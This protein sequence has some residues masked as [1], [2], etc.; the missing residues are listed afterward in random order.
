[1]KK[2]LII[3][4]FIVSF[5]SK[6]VAQD[7]HFGVQMSPSFS[8]MRTDNSKIN[9]AGAA[10][11]LKLA[12]IAE[13]RF[14]QSYAI[15]TGIGFHFNTG[16]RLQVDAPSNYW[17]KAWPNFDTKPSGK[18]DSAAFP[19]E[20]R[21]RHSISYV[22]IPVG[23]KMRTPETGSHVRYFAE[24][25]ITFGF[26]S[27]A[28]GA[29]VGSNKLDQEKIDIKSEVS[30]IN[31]SWGVGGGVEYVI[32]NNTAIVGG[33]YFQRGFKDVTTD[34]GTTFDADG[35]SNARADKSKGVINSL[36]IRLGVMF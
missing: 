2:S 27:K 33:L 5:L 28:Q 9:G 12:L 8:W 21:F 16:G 36:T 26:L 10:T 11:G 17:T 14:S 31:M 23:L 30:N 32:S 13:N 29:I 19:K 25:Q 6:T 4:A 18:A 35:K 22:E 24:P 1:M 3:G 7:L 20:T 34:D 15:S